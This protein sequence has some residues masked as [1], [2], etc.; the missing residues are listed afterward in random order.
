MVCIAETDTSCAKMVELTDTLRY[1]AAGPRDYRARPVPVYVRHVWEFQYV[2]GVAKPTFSPAGEA[3]GR[4]IAPAGKAEHAL[5]I[6][7][8]STAHGWT[9]SEDTLS[10]VAVFHVE[11]VEPAVE[12]AVGKDDWI[13]IRWESDSFLDRVAQWLSDEASELSVPP[14][15]AQARFYAARVAT[16]QRLM[17]TMVAR[18][19]AHGTTGSRFQ[20]DD[21]RL[22]RAVAWFE[23]HMHEG[24]G[25][26]QTA[27]AAYS[28]LRHLSRLAQS[29]HRMSLGRLLHTRQMARALWLLQYGHQS[30][31][32]T[33]QACGY[34]NTSAFSRA[35]RRYFGKTPGAIR[36][37]RS[38]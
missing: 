10:S 8:P 3:A 7:P 33:A 36:A 37:E 24:V 23:A 27:C 16:V 13:A 20:R 22:R 35:V 4:E 18:V 31:A 5:W 2:S 6:F 32:Q 21:Q 28:S 9:S 34:R 30:V 26:A 11:S 25:M 12:A 29:Y 17:S 38:T 1:A 14:D 15:P 19:D